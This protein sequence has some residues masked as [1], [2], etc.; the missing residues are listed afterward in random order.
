MLEY[1]RTVEPAAALEEFLVA[2][3][4]FVVGAMR[5]TISNMLGTITATP[6]FFTVTISTVGEN[7]AML[8][9][10]VVL[11][12]YMFKSAEERLRLRAALGGGG[13]GGGGGGA[14]ASA[15]S[16]IDAALFASSSGSGSSGSF[17]GSSSD[18][19]ASINSSSGIN[20]SSSSSSS[21]AATP[22]AAF[23]DGDD[24]YA[25]GVQK[26][27]VKGEVLR[28]HKERGVEALPAAEYIERLEAEVARLRAARAPEAAPRARPRLPPAAAWGLPPEPS[29]AP[30]A[31]DAGGGD[32]ALRRRQEQQQ[33]QTT[34]LA[35]RPHDD[36]NEL[37]DF[38]R[39][40]EPATVSELTA[41]AAPETA[42][43]MEAFV[44]RL[45]GLNGGADRDALRRAASETTAHEM[46]QLLFWLM[47]VGWRL[48][49]LES[50]L[51]MERRAELP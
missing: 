18:G 30:S 41:C 23:L 27:R 29:V 9:N 3:P 42:A 24:A 16:A 25:P 51:E 43:A 5:Q 28:W 37:L 45:L 6:Q 10:T 48:R 34:A 1:V 39:S 15:D 21:A 47:V 49:A 20:S 14:L 44:E 11:T 7:L 36:R 35:L 13:E 2:E 26:S 17:N 50:A 38:I 8:M 31:L 12:G 33:Q 46:R 22:V 4:P 19:E 32:A 40:L